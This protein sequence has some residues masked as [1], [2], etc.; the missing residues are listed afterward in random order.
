MEKPEEITLSALFLDRD[1]V[2]NEQIVDGYVMQWEDFVFK[3]GVFEALR[4]LRGKCDRMLLVTNQQ[5]VGKGL[6][7]MEDIELIH[8]RMQAELCEHGCAFDRIYCCPHLAA[9]N[10]SCRKPRPGMAER[11]FADFP[12]IDRS[13]SVMAGDTLSD[14]LFAKNAGLIPVHV[15]AVREGEFD[16]IQKITPYHFDTLLDFANQIQTFGL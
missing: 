5:C 1:G 10:C 2:L 14:I 7:S 15:G 13:H 9:E 11:A 16:E 6:C 3:E 12:D 8:A 4:L